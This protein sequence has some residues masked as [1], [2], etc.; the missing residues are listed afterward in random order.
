MARDVFPM[1]G[2]VRELARSGRY[3]RIPVVLELLADR[4]TTIEAMRRVRAALGPRMLS[5]PRCSASCAGGYPLCHNGPV[6]T[7]R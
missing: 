7:V 4:F 5:A 3:R 2:E 6:Q 1:R